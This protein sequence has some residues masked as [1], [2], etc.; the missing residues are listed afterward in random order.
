MTWVLRDKRARCEECGAL[1]PRAWCWF[2]EP[3]LVTRCYCEPCAE[4]L[5]GKEET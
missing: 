4:R 3:A 1:V 5:A 2:A